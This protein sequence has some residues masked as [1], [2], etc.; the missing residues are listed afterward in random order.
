MDRLT[1]LIERLVSRE[2]YPGT[3][4]ELN[5][6]IGCHNAQRRFRRHPQL[7][8]TV[9]FRGQSECHLRGAKRVGSTGEQR[10]RAVTVYKLELHTAVAQRIAGLGIDGDD[11]YRGG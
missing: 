3:P 5:R 1:G 7:A 4:F 2:Q 9:A 10:R 6:L 11:S 8:R